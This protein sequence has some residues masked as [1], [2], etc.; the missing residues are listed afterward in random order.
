MNGASLRDHLSGLA[1]MHL[2][3]ADRLDR[4][5]VAD[6]F[7]FFA[8]A[9]FALK[10]ANFIHHGR[11]DGVDVDWS[12]FARSL[13]DQAT[14]PGNTRILEAVR[15][16]QDKPPKKQV[17]TDGHLQWKNRQCA[18]PDDPEFIVRSVTTVRNNLFHGGKEAVGLMAERDRELLEHSLLALAY[19]VTLNEQVREAFRE[20]GPDAAVA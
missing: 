1:P 12:R 7:M 5:L 19:W 6:F 11:G 14:R 4:E 9:E 2:F 17:Y 3:S 10:R 16:L 15:Y 13:G 18:N 8:R 20:L